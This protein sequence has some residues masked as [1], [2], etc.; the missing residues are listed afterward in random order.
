MVKKI[1][2]TAAVVLALA[3]CAE[4]EPVQNGDTITEKIYRYDG[5]DLHCVYQGSGNYQVMSCDWVRYHAEN[6]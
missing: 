5:A 3:G 2:A 1:F 4:G 6:G